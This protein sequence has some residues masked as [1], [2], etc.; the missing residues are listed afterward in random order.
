MKIIILTVQ[1]N[2]SG[3]WRLGLSKEDSIK[4][5]SH[6]E[7]VCFQLTGELIIYFKAACGASEK[8]AYDFNNKKLSIWI[9][10]NGF[11]KYPKENEKN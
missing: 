2:G 7:S 11:H 1:S 5:F 10:E 6:R 8:K 9:V 3:G 4:L